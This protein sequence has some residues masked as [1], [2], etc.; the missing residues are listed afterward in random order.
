MPRKARVNPGYTLPVNGIYQLPGTASLED[1]ILEAD[2]HRPRIAVEDY[3]PIIGTH[4]R[5]GEVN[6]M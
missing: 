5:D 2:P 6:P 3:L 1:L 4:S